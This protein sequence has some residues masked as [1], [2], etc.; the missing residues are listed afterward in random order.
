MTPM[1]FRSLF[2]RKGIFEIA[3]AR[4]GRSG[5]A[6]LGDARGDLQFVILSEG[7]RFAFRIALRSRRT[8][9]PSPLALMRL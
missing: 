9:C 5:I 2:E 6:G 7:L 4:D 8:S 3:A 1:P